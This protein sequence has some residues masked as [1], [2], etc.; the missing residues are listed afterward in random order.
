[1]IKN[2]LS[3]LALCSLVVGKDKQVCVLN[4]SEGIESLVL[5][6]RRDLVSRCIRGHIHRPNGAV[7]RCMRFGCG[8]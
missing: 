1:M 7:D 2:S 6:P 3:A 8:C 4:S 5:R